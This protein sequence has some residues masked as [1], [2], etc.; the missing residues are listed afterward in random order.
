MT[1][2]LLLLL[3]PPPRPAQALSPSEQSIQTSTIAFGG[4]P[5]AFGTENR[6]QKIG[7][8]LLVQLLGRGEVIEIIGHQLCSDPVFQQGFDF[9]GSGDVASPG[10]DDFIRMHIS[11]GLG[12]LTVDLDLPV[13]TRLGRKRSGFVEPDSPQPF[14]QADGNFSGSGGVRL[15]PAIRLKIGGSG[16]GLG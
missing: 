7:V 9:H 5:G 2:L 11:G 15:H 12:V 3:I 14:V 4:A 13:G 16:R 6:R 10:G 1:L 8:A